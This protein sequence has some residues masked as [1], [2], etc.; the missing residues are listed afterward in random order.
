LVVKLVA[1]VV[2]SRYFDG[3]CQ[4]LCCRQKCSVLQAKISAG[5]TSVAIPAS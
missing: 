3:A 1:K 5:T 2:I 4:A